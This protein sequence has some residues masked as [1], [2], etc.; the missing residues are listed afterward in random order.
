MCMEYRKKTITTIADGSATDYIGPFNGLVQAIYLEDVDSAD[1][2]DVTITDQTTG[3]PVLTVT[4]FAADALYSP[5]DLVSD[6]AGADRAGIATR[7]PVSGQLKVV[8]AQGGNTK[9]F[10]IHAYVSC[11]C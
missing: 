4:N 5:T 1:T 9:S 8:V 10:H 2:A 11:G 7:V 3:A 6:L